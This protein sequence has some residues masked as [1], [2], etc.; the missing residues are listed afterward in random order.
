[1]AQQR[2]PAGGIPMSPK[3]CQM[4]KSTL[5][6]PLTLS[7]ALSKRRREVQVAIGRGQEE[8]MDA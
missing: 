3:G 1:M 5:T 7:A 4:A 8:G 6:D 2:N